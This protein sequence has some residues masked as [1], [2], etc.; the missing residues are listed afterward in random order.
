MRFLNRILVVF[1][2]MALIGCAAPAQ[3]EN[4]IYTQTPDDAF[5]PEL[6]G[7]M[8]VAPVQGGSETNPLWVSKINNSTFQKA[9]EASL[10][11]HGLL[12]N[13]GRFN[14]KVTLLKLQQPMFGLDLKVITSVNYIIV[15]N[16]TKE[17]LFDEIIDAAH[18]ATF[19]D[20]FDAVTRLKIA[21]EGSGKNNIKI[22]LEQ[23]SELDV[24]SGQLSFTN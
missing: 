7:Q 23:L 20:A 9:L 2:L 1:C 11:I 6:R 3:F 5:D 16:K 22:F 13:E 21:N 18:T 17:V 12:V 10:S 8:E 19:G 15:D 14:L 24:S 4:M